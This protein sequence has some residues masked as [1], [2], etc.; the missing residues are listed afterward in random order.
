MQFN[1]AVG[2]C[3][4]GKAGDYIGL[5]KAVQ[6]HSPLE[7][8][9]VAR[10]GACAAGRLSSG[11]VRNGRTRR[12]QGL[13]RVTPGTTASPRLSTDVSHTPRESDR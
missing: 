11:R 8:E 5:I 10:N 7:N 1:P 3:L 6:P 9:E 12:N 2:S 13:A 4:H